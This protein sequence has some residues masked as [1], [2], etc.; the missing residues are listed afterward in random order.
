MMTA[1]I[2]VTHIGSHKG[3]GY[4]AGLVRIREAVDFALEA[5]EGVVVALELGAG[6]GNSIGSRFEQIA[7]ILE[8]LDRRADRVGIC[9]DTAHLWGSGYDIHTAQGVNEMFE[10]LDRYVGFDRLKVVHLND[11]IQ[12]LGSHVD[13]HHHIGEG[14]IGIEGFAAIV[15]HPCT[16]DLPGIIETPG[17]D[18][19]GFDERNMAVLR[20]LR[21]ATAI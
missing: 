7:D 10:A 3:M 2:V 21:H 20:S 6:A 18:E 1:G 13:R 15:N 14:R 9:I 8:G 12:T 11:S 4:E 17:K 19:I 5:A 16:R